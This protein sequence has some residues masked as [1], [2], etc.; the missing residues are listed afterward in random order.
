[1]IPAW[2]K[3]DIARILREA[4]E[5]KRDAQK[6]YLAS[7]CFREWQAAMNE[8][9]THIKIADQRY[10]RA[11]TWYRRYAKVTGKVVDR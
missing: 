7:Q 2:Q 8:M 9:R 5:T 1:M 6:Q 11:L 3:K 10:Y 4:N